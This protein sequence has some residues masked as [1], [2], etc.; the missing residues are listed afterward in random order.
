MLLGENFRDLSLLNLARPDRLEPLLRG[1][2]VARLG[3]VSPDGNWLAYES[4]ESGDRFEIF[5]RPFP[6]VSGRREKVSVEGGRFPVWGPT[7]SN[8]LYF[9]DLEGGM[10][11]AS[12]TLSPSVS[13]GRVAKLFDW[14][15]PPNGPSGT[16]YD[17]SSADGRF[18]LEKPATEGPDAI[19]ISVVLNWTEELKRFVP[20]N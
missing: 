12:V 5:L 19:N 16:P 7:G 11:A 18:L 15:K 1:E 9:V 2:F 17:V 14:E 13:L 10:M 6:N 8:E 4:N 20:V 3:V